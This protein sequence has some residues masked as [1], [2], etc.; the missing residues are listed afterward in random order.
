MGAMS[1]S[2]LTPRV[3]TL[4]APLVAVRA[5]GYS[6]LGV[7]AFFTLAAAVSALIAI[8]VKPV[9]LQIGMGLLAAAMIGAGVGIRRVMESTSARTIRIDPA[10]GS[11]RFI[12]TRVVRSTFLTVGFLLIAPG[13]TFLVLQYLAIPSGNPVD[14]KRWY[15]L[16]LGLLGLC[17]VAHELWILRIPPGLT[18]T[19]FGISG[20]RGVRLIRLTWDEI[21]TVGVVDMRGAHLLLK[22]TAGEL[23]RI[24]PYWIGSDP[25]VVAPIIWYFLHNPGQRHLLTDPRAAI[26]QVE[27]ATVE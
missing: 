25:N 19:E 26:Q 18:L 4:G 13:L 15:I 10:A 22:T 7:T 6:P 5:S 8:F 12:S 3:T 1:T 17:I 27:E 20:T 24:A 16:G 21:A 9:A 2:V 23:I 14:F 11:V